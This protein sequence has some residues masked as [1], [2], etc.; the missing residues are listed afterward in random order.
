MKTQGSSKTD[1]HCTAAMV[2]TT[3]KDDKAV[4]VL[5]KTHYGH[6]ASLG[7]LRLKEK[8]RLAVAGKLAQGVTF[9][10]IL[11]DV[12]DSVNGSF[13]RMHLMTRKDIH[14]IDKAFGIHTFQRH[15]D[16]AV[17]VN[18]LVQELQSKD[19]NPIVLYVQTTR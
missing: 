8:D 1:S 4:H 17:S 11:D 6:T 3:S 14:N 10:R 9:Q 12:R 7:H 18:L 13:E 19:N 2:V 16:D 15:K 5:H